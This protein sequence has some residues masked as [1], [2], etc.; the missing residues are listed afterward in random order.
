MKKQR[1]KILALLLALVTAFSFTGCFKHGETTV[2]KNRTQLYVG[3]YNGGWGS[4]WLYSAKASFEEM[5]KEYEIVI[6]P[7]KDDYEYATLKEAIKT[8]PND[9]YITA[10]S[11]YNYIA[12][13]TI[14]DIS[15]CL[16]A[17][18]GDVGESGNTIEKKLSSDY[19]DFY[20]TSAGKYY[21][22]PFG[23]SLWGLNYDVDLFEE[24][25]LYI[26]VSDGSGSNITWTDGKS[27]S[28]PK[29]AG[30]DGDA[31]T[32]DDGCPVT[33]AEFKALLQRMRSK[34]ITPFTW[35]EVIGYNQYI[36]LS[37]W[38]DAEGKDN[39]DIIKNLS[40][41]FTGYEGQNYDITKNTGYNIN[42]MLGKSYAVEFAREIASNSNNY[43]SVA[44]AL[45][46]MQAQ[47]NY[48]ESKSKAASGD[49]NR[50]AFIL[51]GGHWYNESKAYI[52]E[53]NKTLYSDV[54]SNGRRFSVMP[55]PTFDDRPGTTA[56]YLESSHQ[57]SMFVNAQ[58]EKAD[59]AKLF[60]RYM[61]TD[62]I[63]KESARMSGINRA[64][65]Y[66]LTEE[67][68]STMPHYYSEIYKLHHSDKVNFVN[69]RMSNNFYIA[70]QSME[71]FV[72]AWAGSFLNNRGTKTSLSE[73]L[74]DFVEYITKEG[75]TVDKYVKGTAET[76]KS[77]FNK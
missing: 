63:L 41:S 71:T 67:E 25:S 77:A 33:F 1:T 21:A 30:R 4:D 53:T 5:Y 74:T 17:D 11:Y 55:F 51:D 18:M 10:C 49:G 58:T 36:W 20:K 31:G 16:T 68:L 60:I 75:L 69:L 50:I 72:W 64:C 35:S 19:T 73:P 2:D 6:T 9:M 52:E 23:N 32:Y 46:F 57:F 29:S 65:T 66:S 39:F 42:Y 54:Y 76:Y 27:G 8:D 44:G 59:L 61:C 13:G 45:G 48:I 26:A 15:D 22:V 38:A 7:K 14:L 3:V 28:A 40:G 62:K 70:D 56:T 12:D 34:N 43:S 37:L 24:E 47:D